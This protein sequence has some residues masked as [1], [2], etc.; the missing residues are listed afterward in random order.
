MLGER[1]EKVSRDFKILKNKKCKGDK[2]SILTVRVGPKT[3][4]EMTEMEKR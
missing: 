2:P 4:K 1:D 3:N